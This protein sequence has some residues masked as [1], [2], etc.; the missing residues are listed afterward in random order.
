[1]ADAVFPRSSVLKDAALVVGFTLFTAACARIAI[2]FPP[3][4]AVPITGQTL[5]VLLSGAL[6]GA[7][8][9]AWSQ[10]TYLAAGV[11]GLPVFAP[12]TPLGIAAL[13]GPSGGY[14]V[15]FVL[16]A[17]AVGLLAERGWDRRWWTTAAAML[18]GNGI[19]HLF[20]LLRLASFLPP[21]AL[22]EAGLIPYLPGD[23]LKLALAVGV[24]P[25]GWR[26]CA[27]LGFQIGK[28]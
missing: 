13:L 11:A 23:A 15:G 10:L 24:V 4:F 27:W 20:G 6:L 2:Y 3:Y 14:L 5:A 1:M 21:Q 26:V 22:W 12:R 25:S 17:F 8:R 28:G 9:G 16:A 7:R 18:L 19:I